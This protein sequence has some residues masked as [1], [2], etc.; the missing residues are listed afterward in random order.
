MYVWDIGNNERED[1]G[2][3]GW[4]FSTAQDGR[5]IFGWENEFQVG[6]YGFYGY[7]ICFFLQRDKRE[8]QRKR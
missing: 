3:G 8:T 2:T 4:G 1:G 6:W 7:A 5:E